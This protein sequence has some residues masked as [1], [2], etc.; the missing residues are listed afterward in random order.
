[1]QKSAET[2][3]CPHCA[4]EILADA[5]KCKH[6]GEFLDAKRVRNYQG[7]K[8]SLF[9]AFPSRIACPNCGYEGMPKSYTGGSMG[10]EIVLWLFF[11]LPGF[12][13]SIWRLS[14]RCYV[15]PKCG[16]KEISRI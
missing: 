6:C 15:C 16:C 1:M 10:I 5:K 2:K 11:L 12:I 7:L 14:T 9:K 4:E 8:P 3:K 13:Y